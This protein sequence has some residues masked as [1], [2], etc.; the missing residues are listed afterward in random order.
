ME[1]RGP[2]SG[3]VPKPPE[4]YDDRKTYRGLVIESGEPVDSDSTRTVAV[5]REPPLSRTERLL[6]SVRAGEWETLAEWNDSSPRDPP[7]AP[8]GSWL[9][10][11]QF[12]GTL[13]GMVGGSFE[14]VGTAPKKTLTWFRPSSLP[15]IVRVW[16]AAPSRALY[17]LPQLGKILELEQGAS[18]RWRLGRRGPSELAAVWDADADGE[19]AVLIASSRGLFRYQPATRVLTRIPGPQAER[20]TS[21]TRDTSGRL[22]GVGNRVHMSTDEGR[23]RHVVDVSL[24]QSPDVR[25]VRANPVA[26][27]AVAVM[28]SGQ[29]VITIAP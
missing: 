17:Y 23:Q 20:I 10:Y 14:V 5:C 15:D 27:G 3:C 21:I 25:I 7:A 16:K 4:T 6:R 19:D 9:D 1:P 13:E 22:W 28:T 8:D 18:G 24:T 29:G 2:L 26:A 11:D 12:R